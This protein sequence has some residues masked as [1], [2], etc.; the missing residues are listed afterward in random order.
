MSRELQLRFGWDGTM[1]ESRRPATATGVMRATR[2]ESAAS[3]A[4]A[5]LAAA[6]LLAGLSGGLARLGLALPAGALA[7]HGAVM[8]GGFF[9]T[10]IPLGRAVALRRLAGALAPLAAGCGGVFAWAL[11]PVEGAQ[12]A[13]AALVS[14]YV[15]AG[16]TRAWSQH[17]VVEAWG[18]ACW[19]LGTLDWAGG[20]PAS[21]TVGWM[22][23][24]VPTI[25]GE[26]RELTQMVRLP[27]AAGRSYAAVVAIGLAAALLAV[28]AAD[29]AV[30]PRADHPAGADRAAPG[31]PCRGALTAM[32][33]GGQRRPARR[34][35]RVGCHRRTGAGRRA[36]R[37][38]RALNRAALPTVPMSGTARHPPPPPPRF[39]RRSALAPTC[40]WC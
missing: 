34:R 22:A 25:A 33:D 17:L 6:N 30:D 9:G 23:F 26:W 18:A 29:G 39:P 10:R 32:A 37:A 19:G 27:P 3:L 8:V 1:H 16:C 7:H 15:Y 4:C 35:D 36:A 31:V 5:A 2:L 11:P 24:L 13:T 12:A 38:S 20:G 14:L 21:A 28:A 40:A